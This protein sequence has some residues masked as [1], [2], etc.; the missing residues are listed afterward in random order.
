MQDVLRRMMLVLAV[1]VIAGS[2]PAKA[3]SFASEDELN[4]YIK[5]VSL[6]NDQVMFIVRS[7][8]PNVVDLEFYADQRKAAWP[9]GKEVYSIKDNH[10]HTYVLNCRRGERICYGAGV[11]GKYSSYWGVGI[12]RRANCSECCYTC[13]GTRSKLITLNP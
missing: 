7:L 3:D 11:R 12:N 9:G 8:H 13:D 6:A 10:W 5:S 1:V 4:R 2:V